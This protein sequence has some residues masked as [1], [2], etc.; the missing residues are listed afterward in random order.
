MFYIFIVLLVVSLLLGFVIVTI[1][2]KRNKRIRKEYVFPC[3]VLF[4][5]IFSAIGSAIFFAWA[6]GEFVDDDPVIQDTFYFHNTGECREYIVTPRFKDWLSGGDGNYT[7]YVYLKDTPP[8]A[9]DSIELNPVIKVTTLIDNVSVNSVVIDE[10]KDIL[11]G[12]SYYSKE[13]QYLELSKVL[14]SIKKKS[15]VIRVEVLQGDDSLVSYTD[16]FETQIAIRN[17]Y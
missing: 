17:Y 16:Y 8:F 11:V 12:E 7:L 1:F 15:Y 4:S 6:F 5:V 3:V 13:A 9:S 2:F 10:K 14:W